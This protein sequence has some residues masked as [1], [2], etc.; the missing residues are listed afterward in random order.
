MVLVTS[1]YLEWL[2]GQAIDDAG[3]DKA[4]YL[5]VKAFEAVDT[6]ISQLAA[7]LWKVESS[8]TFEY[9]IAITGDHST[10]VE[11][12]DHSFEPVPFTICHLKDFVKARGEAAVL[13]VS[14]APFSL[15]I[16]KDEAPLNDMTDLKAHSPIDTPV[17]AHGDSVAAFS[18]IAAA[19]GCLGRFTGSE[20]MG[21]IRS[22]IDK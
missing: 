22:Y 8:G 2:G 15:P 13:A 9:S 21:I 5:K 11:Y 1:S 17:A 20:M 3:H 18:E 16:A 6:M 19:R 10:P 7:M 12:G 14:L 4:L